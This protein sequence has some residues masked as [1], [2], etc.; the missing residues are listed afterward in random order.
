[1]NLE[2]K[3]FVEGGILTTSNENKLDLTKKVK[4]TNKSKGIAIDK[5][6]QMTETFAHTLY[7]HERVANIDRKKEKKQSFFNKHKKQ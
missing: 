3:Y 5:A 1:M 6:K 7:I 4:I 2:T